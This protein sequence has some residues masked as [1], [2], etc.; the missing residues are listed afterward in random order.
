MNAARFAAQLL[1]L[2]LISTLSA[3]A[4]SRF[5]FSFQGTCWTTNAE[6]QMYP[7]PANNRTWLQDY[8]AANGITDLKSISLVYHVN[9][10]ARGDAIEIINP[11]TGATV[12]TFLALFFGESLDRQALTNGD[13]S[14]IRR[15]DYIYNHQISHSIGSSLLHQRTYVDARGATNTTIQ[16]QMQYI[17]LP[18]A[19][20]GTTVCNGMLFTGREAVFPG[21]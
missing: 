7:R 13:G 5:H 15:V 11:T 14:E 9:A 12:D 19:T 17:L 10:D 20:H 3:S 2:S 8:A 18:D 4:Q 1:C 21:R 16:C 6:G